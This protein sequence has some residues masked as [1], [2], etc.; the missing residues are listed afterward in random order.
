MARRLLT[1]NLGAKQP[2]ETLGWKV[3]LAASL[4]AGQTLATIA[5]ATVLRTDAVESPA[6]LKITTPDVPASPVLADTNTSVVF[7]TGAGTGGGKY[8]GTFQLTAS[9]GGQYEL[10]VF[11]AVRNA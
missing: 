5:A 7:W 4:S 6:L 11:I 1:V 2:Y 3:K 9:D 10:D 8:Q